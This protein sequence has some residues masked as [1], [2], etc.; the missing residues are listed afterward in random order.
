MLDIPGIAGRRPGQIE[1]GA[2]MRELMRRELAGDHGA[3]GPEAAHCLGIPVGNTAQ[4]GLRAPGGQHAFGIV[5]VLQRDGHPVQRTPAASGRDLGVRLSRRR[6]GALGH[7][8]HVGIEPCVEGRD[9]CERRLDQLERRQLPGR[10]HACG[11]GQR[12]VRKIDHVSVPLCFDRQSSGDCARK[13]STGGDART[14][15]RYRSRHC[16]FASEPSA[17]SFRAIR[18]RVGNCSAVESDEKSAVTVCRPEFSFND[19]DA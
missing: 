17:S 10:N 19:S 14:A 18:S 16:G 8:R 2:A 9:T 7:E 13:H 15:P 6:E 12:Q 5:D 1:A 3:R 4:A 11:V